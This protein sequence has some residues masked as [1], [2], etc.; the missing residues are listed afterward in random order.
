MSS[1]DSDPPLLQRAY[2]S[3]WLLALAAFAFWAVAYVI[4]GLL[5]VVSVPTG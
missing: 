3:P 1:D 5:D 4:W 2:D